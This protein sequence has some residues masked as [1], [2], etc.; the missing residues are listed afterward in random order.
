VNIDKQLHA[1]CYTL[2]HLVAATVV[3][4]VSGA[5]AAWAMLHWIASG[6]AAGAPG[7]D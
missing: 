7:Q 6:L 1:K 2:A 4:F 3:G 5:I